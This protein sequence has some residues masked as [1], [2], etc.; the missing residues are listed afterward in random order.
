MND[1][2]T[3]DQINALL[4]RGSSQSM[5]GSMASD[6]TTDTDDNTDDERE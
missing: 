6:D 1:D 2:D 5:Y 4:Q 3:Q